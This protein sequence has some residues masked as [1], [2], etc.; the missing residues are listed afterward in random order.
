MNIKSKNFI[1]VIIF[2]VIYLAIIL[3]FVWSLIKDIKDES[4][5]LIF[6]KNEEFSFK[7]QM[8]QLEKFNQEKVNY[9]ESFLKSENAFIDSKNPI[10]LIKFLENTAK[11][12]NVT[13]DILLTPSL[14]QKI[15]TD[16][17]PSISMQIKFSGSFQNTLKFINK[18][19][20]SPYLISIE[21]L[22]MN[23]SEEIIKSKKIVPIIIKTDCLIKIFTK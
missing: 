12:S 19:E 4:L 14:A 13:L 2:I 3:F 9:Q 16:I 21:S 22:K 18:L 23:K 5:N 11:D 1:I 8:F 15:K 20:N 7:E 6:R 17:W 10:I